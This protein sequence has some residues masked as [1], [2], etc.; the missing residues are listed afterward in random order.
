ME[1]HVDIISVKDDIWHCVDVV[2]S[3]VNSL[4]E[5]VLGF[6]IALYEQDQLPE[7]NILIEIF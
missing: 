7:L 1:E 6:S 2:M 5:N 4:F 3:E